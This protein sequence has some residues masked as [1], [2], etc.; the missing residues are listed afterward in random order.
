VFTHWPFIN[1]LLLI[2]ILSIGLFAVLFYVPLF[3]QEG[4]NLTPWHT[5]LVL[6]PQALMM[7]ATMPTA[8][9]IYDR[10]GPRWPAVIGLTLCG[11]GTLLLAHINIDLTRP[12]L[13]TCMVIRAAGI[14]LAMMPIMTGGLSALPANIVSSGS[15]FNTLTQRV[16][17]SFGLAALTALATAQQAQFMSNRASLLSTGANT[18]PRIVAMQ[19]QGP[20]GLIGLWQQTQI[21]V[22]AESYSNV[23]LIAGVCTLGGVLLALRLRS[24]KPG[25]GED[26]EPVE[27]G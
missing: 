14:G 9:R 25:R 4:Q 3:L 2:A 23:F 17:A 16:T 11:V 1:S 20:G 18:D 15:A 10:I 21:E 19:H 27:A 26:S 5:G 8:G 24:G 22:E 13:I 7:M 6:L 12:E